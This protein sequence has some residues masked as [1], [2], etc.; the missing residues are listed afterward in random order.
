LYQFYPQTLSVQDKDDAYPIH[1]LA[2]G[3]TSKDALPILL[4]LLQHESQSLLTK[5]G[6]EET[7]LTIM[8]K[9]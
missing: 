8:A 4:L 6:D 7:P 9:Y 3:R 1:L 2:W 5:D